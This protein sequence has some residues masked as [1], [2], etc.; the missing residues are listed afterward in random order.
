MEVNGNPVTFKVDTGASDNVI[1]PELR[2][3]LELPTPTPLN[4]TLL[5]PCQIVP[6]RRG[7]CKEKKIR[8]Q[9]REVTTDIFILENQET[10]LLRIT[11]AEEFGIV[12]WHNYHVYTQAIRAPK[13]VG[14]PLLCRVNR[15]CQA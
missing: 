8:W 1:R 2:R 7:V 12:K 6:P 11:E 13:R 3:Q 9:N 15:K 5:G 4:E 10:P 14:A